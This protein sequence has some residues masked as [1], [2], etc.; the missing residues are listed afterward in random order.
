MTSSSLLLRYK[1][2]PLASDAILVYDSNLGTNYSRGFS[3]RDAICRRLPTTSVDDMLA[4]Q[5]TPL[6]KQLWS[7][8]NSANESDHELLITIISDLSHCSVGSLS[9]SSCNNDDAAIDTVRYT[10]DAVCLKKPQFTSPQ[11]AQEVTE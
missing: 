2:Q 5:F 11:V 8:L 7:A 1:E 6:S 9:F 3:D 4:K 10:I